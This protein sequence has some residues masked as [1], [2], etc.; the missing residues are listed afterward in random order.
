[1]VDITVTAA[2][3]LP[4]SNAVKVEGV[5]LVALTAGQVVYISDG[6][7]SKEAGLWFLAD[8]DETYSS[9]TAAEI[10]MVPAAIAINTEG[11]S[12]GGLGHS[13]QYRID[14]TPTKFRCKMRSF[15][16]DQDLSPQ[17]QFWAIPML[18]FLWDGP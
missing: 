11:R 17:S 9:S 8:A 14:C 5:A 15:A 10:G 3:V 13:F 4:Q 16:H 2:N 12:N 6:S 18:H 1:M 7:G